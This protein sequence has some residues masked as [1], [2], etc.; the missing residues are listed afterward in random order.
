M[1]SCDHGDAKLGA[2]GLEQSTRAAIGV[3]HENIVIG[4]AVFEHAGLDR[5]CDALW[6]EVKIGGETGEIHVV[7]AVLSFERQNFT[8]QRTTGDEQ[9]AAFA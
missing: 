2:F 6:V 3:D 5:F 7:P 8:R 4:C 1:W 9:E